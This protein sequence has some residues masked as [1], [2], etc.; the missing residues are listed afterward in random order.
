MRDDWR[1]TRALVAAAVVVPRSIEKSP[2]TF[3]LPWDDDLG[4]LEGNIAPVAH[5][6]RADDD[7]L[8][9]QARQLITRSM[10]RSN[11]S[12]GSAA[13]P[14]GRRQR[15]IPRKYLP[16]RS[17]DSGPGS[18]GPLPIVGYK[19][20]RG[21]GCHHIMH[22]TSAPDLRLLLARGFDCAARDRDQESC[23]LIKGVVILTT[24]VGQSLRTTVILV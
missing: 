18:L 6:F 10:P 23:A 16:Q 11:G 5:H 14:P 20:N 24:M 17:V 2:G 3:A 8:L 19:V 4:H 12:Y 9:L 15:G 1:L 22:V 21:Q 7:Q 13:L